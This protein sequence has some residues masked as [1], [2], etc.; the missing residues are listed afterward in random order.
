MFN[1]LLTPMQSVK[2]RAKDGAQT[3]ATAPQSTPTSERPKGR[4]HRFA[5]ELA[6]TRVGEKSRL[7]FAVDDIY[8]D[9]P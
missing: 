4:G 6:D 8:Y 7:M 9:A 3:R 1:N 2:Q 5:S